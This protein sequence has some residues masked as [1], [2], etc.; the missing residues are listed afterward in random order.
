[1]TFNFY[2]ATVNTHTHEAVIFVMIIIVVLFS[3]S[4]VNS[5]PVSPRGSFYCPDPADLQLAAYKAAQ[6]VGQGTETE[7]E[8]LASA[9]VLVQRSPIIHAKGHYDNG[10]SAST[11]PPFSYA[12]LIVQAITSAKDKQLTLSGIYD[13][14]IQTYPFYRR[15]DKGWQ[16][17]YL[18]T[19]NETWKLSDGCLV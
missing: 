1:M 14:I 18:R 7:L 8:N 12:Q 11:K 15:G 4:A 10:Y 16:V 9:A 2:F 17:T 5:C 13:Y 6:A 19:V 3:H